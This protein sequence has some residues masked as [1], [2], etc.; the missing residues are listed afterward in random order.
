M[1]SRMYGSA[2]TRYL[3][4]RE[5][6]TA[7]SSAIISSSMMASVVGFQVDGILTEEMALNW[8]NRLKLVMSYCDGA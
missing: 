7:G 8:K 4:L 5:S 2:E 6:M 3:G 1:L